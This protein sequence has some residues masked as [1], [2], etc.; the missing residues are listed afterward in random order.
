MKPIKKKKKQ[1]QEL[2]G[3][4]VL[5]LL[6]GHLDPALPEAIHTCNFHLHQQVNLLF[7]L[8]Q[9]ELVFCHEIKSHD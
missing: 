9:L 7:A 1:S 4:K 3:E 2:D 5:A 8:G 6:F